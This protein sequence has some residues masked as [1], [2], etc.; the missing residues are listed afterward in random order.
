MMAK[1]PIARAVFPVRDSRSFACVLAA[2][3]MSAWDAVATMQHI[4]RGVALE[5]NPLMDTLIQRHALLFFGVKM[6]LTAMGLMVCYN[7]SHLRTARIGIRF[8][9]GLYGFV[10]GYHLAIILFG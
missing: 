7:Y 1:P 4:G 10:C 2:I 5:A 8:I 6:L 3:V 9:L